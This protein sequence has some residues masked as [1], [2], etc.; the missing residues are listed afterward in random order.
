MGRLGGEYRNEG[1][2]AKM[3]EWETGRRGEVAGLGT[4]YG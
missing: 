3:E 1:E 4:V 2:R